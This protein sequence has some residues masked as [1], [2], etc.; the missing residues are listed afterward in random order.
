MYNL[1][2]D[3]KANLDNSTQVTAYVDG[4][5]YGQVS[6]TANAFF[7]PEKM[8]SKGKVPIWVS[9][10]Y[11]GVYPAQYPVLGQIKNLKLTFNPYEV[12][13]PEQWITAPIESTLYDYSGLGGFSMLKDYA[14]SFD[15][16]ISEW[17]TTEHTLIRVGEFPTF[18]FFSNSE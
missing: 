14:L 11:G 4:V 6:D 17:P 7:Y 1:R 10:P 5:E 15:F 2:I 13:P 18:P 16:E 8:W 3:I 9:P 12:T